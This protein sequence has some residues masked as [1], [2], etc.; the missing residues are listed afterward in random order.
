MTLTRISK[1]KDYRIFR[2]FSWPADLHDF[3]RFNVIY[4][5]N[6]AGKTTLSTLLSQVQLKQAVS[7]GNVELVFEDRIVSGADLGKVPVPNVRVFNR[8]FVG[9]AVFES[10]G[11][12]FPPVYYFGEDSVEKQRRIIKL[13]ETRGALR[14][15]QAVKGTA[16]V[17]AS[18]ARD[19]YCTEQAK[20]I[21]NLLTT[22]GGGPY[23]NYDARPFKVD[24]QRLAALETRP[25][26][27]TDAERKTHLSIRESRARPL[28]PEVIARFPDLVGL[29]TRT[30][31]IL[32]TSVVSSVLAE[33][34]QDP[35][36][37]SWVGQGLGLHRGDRLTNT[38]RFCDQPLPADRVTQLEAHF[39]DEFNK[40]KQLI[41]E[42]IGE[43]DQ[44][45]A[46]EASFA[47][48]AKELLYESL[49]G[50]Y[51]AALTELLSQSKV[52]KGSLETLRQALL[53]KQ[54]D[55][56]GNIELTSWLKQLG[57][58]KGLGHVILTTL[59]VAADGAPFFASFSGTQ[60]LRRLNVAIDKHN[61][62]TGS[63]DVAVKGARDALAQDEVLASLDGWLERFRAVDDAEKKRDTARDAA[64]ELDKEIVHLEAEVRQHHRPAIELN[65]ELAAYLGRSEL[66]FVPEQNGYRIMR[67]DQPAMHL[68]EGERT[69]IAFMYFLK[70]LQGTDFA[71]SDGIVVIDDPVSSL[72]ANSL[73]S[74][75]GF[76]KDRTAKSTQLIILTHNFGFFR[77]VRNWFE[78]INKKAKREKKDRQAFFYMLSPVVQD[79]LRGAKLGKLDS[80][81][82][83]FESEYHYLFKRVY[84]LTL[85]EQGQGLEQYYGMPNLARRLLET[86]LAYRIPGHS[87]DLHGKLGD[88]SGDVAIKT[89]VLRFL[90]TFSHGDA[91]MQP[92]HDLS[93]LSET[94]AVLC[95]VLELVRA[96]DQPHYDAMVEVVRAQA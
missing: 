31:V 36:V 61:K 21:R 67:G 57:S 38:C 70:S 9:R 73:F 51:S 41:S 20:S 50:E 5:W 14:K 4:G 58:G 17:L 88:M 43:V 87:G 81:L 80:F 96:N 95:D 92:E 86:F 44:D 49:Q 65:S 23:N 29:R 39:N 56:F 76:L 45:M 40:L 26:R 83:D 35:A 93:I 30:Q 10:A 84:E 11:T 22:S 94:Q 63:F 2:D 74:A 1:I 16:S 71:P 27:L 55:P 68:S 34:A 24:V 78:S 82:T 3:G 19:T 47:A 85:L 77:Q 33:L 37:A 32:G 6:G 42:L 8:E 79:G 89:R 75:F 53:A 52:L 90:H 69:A 59:A 48:P 28:L 15:E 7:D 54:N 18:Q 60:A 13:T 66:K 62:M 91:V 25:V 12:R 72:D 64:D 46:F